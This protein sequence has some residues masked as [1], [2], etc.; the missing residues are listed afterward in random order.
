MTIQFY[1]QL[2][3]PLGYV[4]NPLLCPDR[5][6]CLPEAFPFLVW[7]AFWNLEPLKLYN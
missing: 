4:F 6:Q 5:L 1:P 3:E 7:V 2:R